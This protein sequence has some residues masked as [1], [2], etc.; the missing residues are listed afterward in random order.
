M[1]PLRKKKATKGGGGPSSRFHYRSPLTQAEG[2]LCRMWA[3]ADI[4]FSHNYNNTATIPNVQLS[5][6]LSLGHTGGR[7]L[8][9]FTA[10]IA[11]C[12]GPA[13]QKRTE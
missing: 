1:R 11:P 12:C 7:P 9:F 5:T 8:A 2:D 10:G 13:G 4:S 3:T 6:I